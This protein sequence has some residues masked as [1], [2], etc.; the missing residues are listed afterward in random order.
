MQAKDKIIVALD[1]D[2]PDK[3]I[4]LVKTLA[5]F[6]GC[7]KIGLE[8]ITAMLASIIAVKDEQEAVVNMAKIRELFQLLKG[9]VFWDG[10]FKD[11]PNTLGG[12]AKALGPLG[13][14]MFNVHASSGIEGMME[15]VA[16]K[17]GSEVLAVTVLTSFEENNAHLVYGAP[18][19][20]KVIQ[21]ARDAKLAGCDGVICSPQELF[22]LGK[23]KELIGLRKVTPGI[24]S[25]EDPPDDQNR[26]LPPRGAMLAGAGQLVIGRP[27]TQASSPQEV[28]EKIAR[29]ISLGLVDRFHTALFDLKKI[30]F[31][32][33]KLKLHEKNPDAPLSPIYL[34]IRELPD[35]LYTLAGD[36]LHDLIIQEGIADFDYVI[37]IPKA[38]E[39]I[40]VALAKA[41]GKPHLRIE[42]TETDG[43]RKITSHILDSFEKGK[44]VLLVDDLVTK[45]DTKR[46]AIQS[47]EANGLEVVATVVLYDREQGGLKELN[48]SGRKVVAMARLGETLDFFVQSKKIKPEKKDEVL[49]YI[50]AN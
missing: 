26:T 16:Q 50:K 17:G 24:R 5:P 19:K 40:G 27:I 20:A 28:A 15:V 41:I 23:Q 2:H 11:I 35:W 25:P 44:R 43:G 39:P 42:K 7:F 6:V 12:A 32:A 13:V 18:S 37:G 29:E 45:A 49:A 21:F 36:V 4:G 9:K 30:K 1:V 34:N 31:G 48:D 33:F 14:K 10:K 8:F 38:G 22:L 46:E 47:V 3:A